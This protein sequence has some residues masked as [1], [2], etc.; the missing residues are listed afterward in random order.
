MANDKWLMI[1][2]SDK[3]FADGLDKEDTLANYRDRFF[4]PKDKDG[5]DVI[6]L[7]GNS[8]GLQPKSVRKFVEQ[9]LKD[10]ETLG[11]EG[12]FRGTNPWLSYHELLTEQTA[13]LTARPKRSSA[14]GMRVGG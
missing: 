12:H 3:D 11:V 2:Q 8:L 4:I 5:K 14:K 10:W 9:E 7:C 13:R 1:F 6:Y